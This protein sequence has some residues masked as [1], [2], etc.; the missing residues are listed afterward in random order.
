MAF[1]AT[2]TP[3]R[4]VPREADPCPRIQPSSFLTL[5][6]FGSPG[7]PPPEQD[8]EYSEEPHGSVECIITVWEAVLYGVRQVRIEFDV[9]L[10]CPVEQG[11]TR[12]LPDP[13]SPLPFMPP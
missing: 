10:S 13:A 3:S 9:R 7:R 8:F 12:F 4:S 1:Q 6:S 11:T 2:V 5:P